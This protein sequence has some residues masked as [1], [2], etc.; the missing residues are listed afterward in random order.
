MKSTKFTNGSKSF[1]RGSFTLIELLI[2]IA[3][4]AILAGMLLPALNKAKQKAEAIRCTSN[5]KQIGT[6]QVGYSSDF[7]GNL[8]P[9]R[10]RIN[11]S[12]GYVWADYLCVMKYVKESVIDCT[13][14][15]NARVGKKYHLGWKDT[16]SFGW[17]QANM[18]Y[19]ENSRIKCPSPLDTSTALM[20]NIDQL[21]RTGKTGDSRVVSCSASN[22]VLVGEPCPWD[23]QHAYQLDP[24]STPRRDRGGPDD[25][26]HSGRSNMLF[27]D[28][29]VIM[30]T[31]AYSYRNFHW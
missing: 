20:L 22:T 12:N 31:A 30:T 14:K 21:I 26:R 6:A 8:P 7:N 28:G 10:Y 4:I 13:S 9:N 19:G 5:M 27:T 18:A 29:H 2:V 1:H 24:Y 23:N 25:T 15:K 11:G 17:N 3:I 16:T